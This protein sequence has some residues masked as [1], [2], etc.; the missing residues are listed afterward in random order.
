MSWLKIKALGREELIVV[1]FTDPERSRGGF[2]GLALGYYAKATG[3]LIYAGKVGTG[4]SNKLLAQLHGRLT[5]LEQSTPTVT[6]P[7]GISRTGVH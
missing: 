4:F 5:A 3:A 7:K 1:G 2:G 6:L